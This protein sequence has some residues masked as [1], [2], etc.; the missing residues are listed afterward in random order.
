MGGKL[1]STP[2]PK[3]N[4]V[5]LCFTCCMSVKAACYELNCMSFLCWLYLTVFND[6]FGSVSDDETF[7]KCV[8]IYFSDPDW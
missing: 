5:L 4:F 6:S 2:P 1:I 8:C 3:K 7:C